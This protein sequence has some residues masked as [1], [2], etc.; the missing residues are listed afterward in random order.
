MQEDGVHYTS[1]VFSAIRGYDGTSYLVFYSFITTVRILKFI[2]LTDGTAMQQLYV[3]FDPVNGETILKQRNMTT[4]E[5]ETR[6]IGFLTNLFKVP[7]LCVPCHTNQ[8]DLHDNDN[9]IS[10]PP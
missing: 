8:F 6:E 3:F 10:I 5:I 9:T 4:D 7:P 2:Y 1:L